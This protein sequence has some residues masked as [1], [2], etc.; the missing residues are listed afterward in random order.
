MTLK[1]DKDRYVHVACRPL[2]I[3]LI[4]V[5]WQLQVNDDIETSTEFAR[6]LRIRNYGYNI[7]NI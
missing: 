1:R 2:F 6:F 3:Q 7:L 4:C 5:C